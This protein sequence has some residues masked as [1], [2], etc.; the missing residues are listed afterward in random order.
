MRVLEDSCAALAVFFLYYPSRR[1]QPAALSEWSIEHAWKACCVM[2]AVSS[3]S[4]ANQRQ[5]DDSG[6]ES[7]LFVRAQHRPGAVPENNDDRQLVVW[8]A[9][10]N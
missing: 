1:Q 6:P 3:K 2:R 8:S 9:R 5:A 4:C 10:E 7:A